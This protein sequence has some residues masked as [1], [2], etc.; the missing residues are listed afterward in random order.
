MRNEE[1]EVGSGESNEELGMRNEEL[2]VEP[3]VRPN[4]ESSQEL[5]GFSGS[6]FASTASIFSSR[7][8]YWLSIGS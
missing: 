5:S 8:V 4:T 7:R 3:D 1:L 2:A 6:H